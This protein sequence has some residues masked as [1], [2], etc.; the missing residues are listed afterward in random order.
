[1]TDATSYSVF[2]FPAAVEALGSPVKPHLQDGEGGAFIRCASIDSSGPLFGMTLLTTDANGQ[3][4]E[5]E[6]MIPHGMVRLVM[7]SH[8]EQDFGFT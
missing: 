6:I 2:L 5:L 3:P 8:N 4:V 1:M 7:S